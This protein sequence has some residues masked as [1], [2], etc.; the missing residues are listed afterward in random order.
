MFKSQHYAEFQD[1]EWDTKDMI[2]LQ[3]EKYTKENMK[4]Y[5]WYAGWLAEQDPYK[6]KFFDE[7]YVDRRDL[8]RKKGRSDKGKQPEEEQYWGAGN[9]RYTVN[10]VTSLSHNL[11]FI[12][13]I[14]DGSSNSLRLLDFFIIYVIPELQEGDIMVMDNCAFHKG[15]IKDVLRDLLNSIGVSLIFLPPYSPGF[16]L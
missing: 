4:K 12:Y 11:P 6:L 3:K 15:Y 1:L 9:S 2:W 5:K 14:I 13:E 8:N 16:S 7:C 10:M